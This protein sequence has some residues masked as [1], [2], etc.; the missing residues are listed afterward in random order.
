MVNQIGKIFGVPKLP[1]VLQKRL[2]IIMLHTKVGT[3]KTRTIVEQY[4]KTDTGSF[5]CAHW[6]FR[7]I[8][9]LNEVWTY[10]SRI[11][12]N[13]HMSFKLEIIKTLIL[14]PK[15]HSDKGKENLINLIISFLKTQMNIH[16]SSLKQ[17]M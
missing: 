13:W 17:T 11:R 2:Y 6:I 9:F 15:T 7:V 4:H 12:L 5:K 14:L 10:Q 1:W 16:F 8:L 3:N